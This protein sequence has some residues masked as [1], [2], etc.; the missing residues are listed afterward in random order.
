[1]VAFHY[2]VQP[3]PFVNSEFSVHSL[4]QYPSTV[5]DAVLIGTFERANR[6][7][8]KLTCCS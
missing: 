1:M 2:I 3:V 7:I 6:F 8:P 4:L 5:A